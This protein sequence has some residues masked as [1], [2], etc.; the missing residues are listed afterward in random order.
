M[1]SLLIKLFIKKWGNTNSSDVRTRYGTL[2]S[3]VGIISNIILCAIKISVGWLSNSISIIADGLNN[4]ADM[5]SSVVNFISSDTPISRGM[6]SEMVLP[7]SFLS[8]RVPRCRSS[9]E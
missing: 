6:T 5:G 2:G 1:T 7:R 3:V 8:W 4:L 9:T